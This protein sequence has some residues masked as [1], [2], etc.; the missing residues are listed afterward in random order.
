ML[1]SK[2]VVVTQGSPLFRRLTKLIL[3]SACIHATTETEDYDDAL[4]VLRARPVDLLI[5]EHKVNGACALDCVRRIRD[6]DS[7][8]NQ[9]VPII[10]LTEPDND[11]AQRPF[12]IDQ[13]MGAGTTACVSK[14]LSI[15]KL[16][17]AVVDA[18][19]PGSLERYRDMPW[20][21]ATV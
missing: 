14:P 20:A 16:I 8:P 2:H 18:L 5:L 3:A 17:P 12:S 6:D 10:I 4:C 9:K 7:G 15:R 1:N 19:E 21:S 11:A 13:A